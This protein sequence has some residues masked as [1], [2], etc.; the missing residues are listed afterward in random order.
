M[1]NPSLPQELMEVLLWLRPV[2]HACS[3]ES[4][5]YLVTGLLLGRAQAGVVRASLVAPE[6]YNWRRLPD[7]LRRN[8]W[9]GTGL[10]VALTS[11]VLATLYPD[12]FPTHLF[13][14]VDPTY[15]EKM[16]AKAIEGVMSHR[17]P[18]PK[19]GQG[20]NLKGHGVVLIAHL[21][22]QSTH[23]LKAFLLGGLLYVKQA[24]FVELSGKLVN[25]LPLPEKVKNVLVTDRGLTSIKLS[26]AVLK[27]GVYTLGRVKA[28]ACFYLPATSADYKG[29]GRHPTY[30]QMLR[31]D[32]AHK[33][34]T[35]KINML[36]PVDGKLKE[37]LVYRG[38]F[39]RKG[40]PHPVDL[41]RVEVKGLSPWLL[42][43]TDPTLST[44]EAVFAYYGRSQIE[45]AIAESKDLGLD[46]YRGRRQAGIQRWPMVIGVVHCLLQ[47]I[48]VGA[49]KLTL[50]AQNW[51]WYRKE[52]TV[53]SIQRRLFQRIQRVHFL[54]LFRRKR[55]DR[56][57]DKAA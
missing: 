20:R 31:A 39:L 54:D 36:V 1:A 25:S 34:A 9:S 17:R 28:N 10:M 24:T 55:K 52:T 33:K 16:Y 32:E 27:R 26:K 15:L 14:V 22:R 23:R 7:L 47:L 2:F 29:R 4:F 48:A 19:S 40:F 30:G 53:G 18:H 43:L 44:E 45:V 42:I 13:W 56:K 5:L 21:Y 49:L 6:G 12:G 51:P 37:G 3:W 46:Q 35:Q 57:M 8:A 11:M 41:I 38:T 50:P